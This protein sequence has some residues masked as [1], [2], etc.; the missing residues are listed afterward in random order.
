MGAGVSGSAPLSPYAEGPSLEHAP[1]WQPRVSNR[2]QS[3][4]DPFAGLVLGCPAMREVRALV[5]SLWRQPDAP[6]VISGEL[7][8]GKEVIARAIHLGGAQP[9]A[10]FVLVNCAALSSDTSESPLL[11]LMSPAGAPEPRRQPSLLE[12][13]AGGTVFFDDI[14]AHPANAREALVRLVRHRDAPGR[15]RDGARQSGVRII[16]SDG[17]GM[18]RTSDG[19]ALQRF[20]RQMNAVHVALPPLRERGKDIVAIAQLLLRR[21]ATDLAVPA[22]TLT[23]DLSQRIVEHHWP[24]NVWEL[25]QALERTLLLSTNG[26]LELAMAPSPYVESTVGPA[27]LHC[28]PAS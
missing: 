1:V 15:P 18:R 27:V 14:L 2:Q 28:S 9:H 17:G 23:P 13:A 19:P 6:V 5:E 20:V 10:P 25:R 24:G 12:I 8:T 3:E 16:V 22:P 7:G 11:G 26:P 21:L 4:A